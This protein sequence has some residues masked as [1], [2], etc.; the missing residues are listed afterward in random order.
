MPDES[1]TI[2]IKDTQQLTC[3]AAYATVS[4]VAA[5]IPFF[6]E[7]D[8]AEAVRFPSSAEDLPV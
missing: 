3:R 6:S 4:G 7:S 5:F 8:D 2:I 1:I